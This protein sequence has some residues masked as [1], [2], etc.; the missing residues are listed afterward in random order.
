MLK[1]HRDNFELLAYGAGGPTRARRLSRQMDRRRAEF[2]QPDVNS[3]AGFEKLTYGYRASRAH[4]A[5]QGGRAA[6]I[7]LLKFR[8]MSN[9]EINELSL[10][11]WIPGPA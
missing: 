5:M 10:L 1:E 6:T 2:S 7:D 3:R 9:Q 11:C 4:C 8:S